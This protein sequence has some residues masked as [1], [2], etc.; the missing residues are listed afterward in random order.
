MVG[1]VIVMIMIVKRRVTV[2]GLKAHVNNNSIS[3]DHN[4]NN[5]NNENNSSSNHYGD[6]WQS[7]GLRPLCGLGHTGLCVQKFQ[8]SH[9]FGVQALGSLIVLGKIRPQK[10]NFPKSSL[11]KKSLQMGLSQ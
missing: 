7:C 2:V 11:P 5:R 6:V 8:G 9:A 4:N 10:C 3:S 1:V